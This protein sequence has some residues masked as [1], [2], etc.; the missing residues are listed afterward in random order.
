MPSL[1]ECTVVLERVEM[2][3]VRSE[4]DVSVGAHCEKSG[5]L[6]AE[7]ISCGGIEVSDIAGQVRARAEGDCRFEQWR[8]GDDLLQGAEKVRQRGTSGGRSTEKHEGVAGAVGEFV[9]PAGLRARRLDRN[10][11]G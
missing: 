7:E 3:S 11:I 1:D 2:V 6:D 4:A 10:R 9:K 8:I 5:V